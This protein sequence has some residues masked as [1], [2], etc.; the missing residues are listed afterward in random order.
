MKKLLSAKSEGHIRESIDFLSMTSKAALFGSTI[1]HT[2]PSLFSTIGKSITVVTLIVSIGKALTQYYFF[3]LMTIII[4]IIGT[5]SYID[6]MRK[7]PGLKRGFIQNHI[8]KAYEKFTERDVD[9]SLYNIIN[10]QAKIL[11]NSTPKNQAARRLSPMIGSNPNLSTLDSPS[12][13][14]KYRKK[15]V[16][17][18]HQSDTSMK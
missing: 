3:I 5:L 15:R 12:F 14:S 2:F 8:Y 9:S 6:L 16:K 4:I 17:D 10:Q 11:T 13:S 7:H 1:D 18:E